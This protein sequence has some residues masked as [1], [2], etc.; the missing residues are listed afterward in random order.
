MPSPSMINTE[1]LRDRAFW[2]EIG[3]QGIGKAAK[4]L[5]PGLMRGQTV[6]TDAQNLSVRRL[7]ARIIALKGV[8]LGSSAA[9]KV[10]H[11]E[12]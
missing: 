12:G 1:L 10:K 5:G 11:M 9:G 2:M 7:K 3:Q 4:L 6:Y 8:D